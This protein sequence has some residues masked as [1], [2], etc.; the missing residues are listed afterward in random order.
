MGVY[1]F[2]WEVLREYLVRDEANES[3]DHDFGKNI[4]PMMLSEGRRMWSYRF[5]GY[6]RDV[7]D[8]S[9]IL[10]IEYGSHQKNSGVQSV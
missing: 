9:S 5:S 10:G 2:N 7:G 1:I 4:I 8:D 6:W 3:S